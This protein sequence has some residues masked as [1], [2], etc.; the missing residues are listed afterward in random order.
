M[1]NRT[2]NLSNPI[3]T[4]TGLIEQEFLDLVLDLIKW[5]PITGEGSP[6]GVVTAAQYTLYIDTTGV[7]GSIEY[8]KM[9]AEIDGDRSKGWVLV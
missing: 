3:V 9:Q 5:K 6:E 2:L 4:P 7:S 8:R 1:S